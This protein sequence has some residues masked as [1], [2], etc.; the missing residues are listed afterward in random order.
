MVDP[1]VTST[2]RNAPDGFWSTDGS[3][4]LAVMSCKQH[5]AVNDMGGLH[6]STRAYLHL[7]LNHLTENHACKGARDYTSFHNSRHTPRLAHRHDK[8][9]CDIR[10]A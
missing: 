4:K 2:T 10:V 8:Y 3:E 5:G 1:N 6:I 9:A 7:A